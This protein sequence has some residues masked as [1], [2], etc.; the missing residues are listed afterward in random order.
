MTGPIFKFLTWRRASSAPIATAT[1]LAG[2]V[3]LIGGGQPARF[4]VKVTPPSALAYLR[5]DSTILG[6]FDDTTSWSFDLA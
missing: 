2:P 6:S 5:F 3:S 4:H 1:R